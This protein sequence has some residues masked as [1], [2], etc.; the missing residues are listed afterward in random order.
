MCN[1]V[2]KEKLNT[3][4][5]IK[6]LNSTT[7]LPTANLLFVGVNQIVQT[8]SHFMLTYDGKKENI[9][10]GPIPK[11]ASVAIIPPTKISG[12]ETIYKTHQIYGAKM[13]VKWMEAE[14]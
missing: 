4:I 5:N 13:D 9:G 3:H 2:A 1:G 8:S 10:D 7:S 11:N 14:Y 12:R 6:N